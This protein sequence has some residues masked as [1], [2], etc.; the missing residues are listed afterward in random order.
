MTKLTRPKVE[1]QSILL[2]SKV[3]VDYAV[4][5]LANLPL[6]EENP[7]EILIREQ[8]KQRKPDANAAMWAGPLRDIEK[9][10]WSNGRQFSAEAWHQFMKIKFLPDETD[11]PYDESTGEGFNPEWVLDGYRKWGIDPAGN[12][13]LE[14]STTK[15]TSKGM[16]HYLL[17]V[18][19]EASSE[20]GAI[21][22]ERRERH[23]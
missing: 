17:L 15:L 22:T 21:F 19:S 10:A 14:G 3:Q 11:P 23:E 4:K 16:H 2:R 8:V 13:A 1:T 18:E 5:R 6:D 9:T 20:Y 7:V 12:R